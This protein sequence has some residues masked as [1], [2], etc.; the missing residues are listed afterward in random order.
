MKLAFGYAALLL[1]SFGGSSSVHL[2]LSSAEAGHAAQQCRTRIQVVVERGAALEVVEVDVL[3]D[4]QVAVL[5]AG[6]E[7]EATRIGVDVVAEIGAQVV[8]ALLNRAGA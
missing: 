1:P 4:L 6:N 7:P 5:G 8:D 2:R 3:P